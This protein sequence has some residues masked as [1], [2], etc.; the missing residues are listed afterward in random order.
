MSMSVDSN[1]RRDAKGSKSGGNRPAKSGGVGGGSKKGR[2]QKSTAAVCRQLS[3][4]GCGGVS[5]P[6]G[7]TGIQGIQGVQGI[8]GPAGQPGFP[9]V[10]GNKGQKGTWVESVALLLK[11]C[12]ALK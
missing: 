3:C 12:V 10:H 8:Q 11:T 6:P 2:N 5:G 1:S 7:P 9:G 4:C